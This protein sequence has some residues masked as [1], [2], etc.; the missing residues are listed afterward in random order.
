[1]SIRVCQE[2]GRNMGVPGPHRVWTQDDKAT[3][4][5]AVTFQADV[6]QKSRAIPD[7]YQSSMR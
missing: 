1:N 3:D 5:T 7:S 4:S 2:H 6:W